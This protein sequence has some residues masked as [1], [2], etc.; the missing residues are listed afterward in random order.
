[1]YP[2][3]RIV[4]NA[5]EPI[6]CVFHTLV[7]RINALRE[8]YKGGV[9]AF[10]ETHKPRCN[11]SLVALCAMSE[12]D[13]YEPILDLEKNGLVAEEDFESFDAAGRVIGFAMSLKVGMGYPEELKFDAPWLKGFVS[14]GGVMVYL[15]GFE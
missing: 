13:L 8:K 9:R 1:M 10:V 4:F 6:R 14:N 2:Q 7:V 5:D 15:S 12:E 3:L 11:S